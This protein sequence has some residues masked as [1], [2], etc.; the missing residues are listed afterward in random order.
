MLLAIS[1][2]Q[3]QAF[4]VASVKVNNSNARGSGIPPIHQGQFTAQNVT[5]KE[6]IVEAYQLQQF[7]LSGGPG[8]ASAER[9]DINAKAS[10]AK[11]DQVLKMLQGL[12]T[13]RFQLKLHHETKE[14]PVYAITVA[15]NGP[16]IHA[17]DGLDCDAAPQDRPCGGFRVFQRRR[18]EGFRASIPEFGNVLSILMTRI[19]QDNTGLKGRFDFKLDW[20]PDDL[21]SKG[22]ED[23][24]MAASEEGR[25]SIFSAMQEQL[26]LKLE[27]K[28]GPVEILV[29]DRV[30][31]PTEN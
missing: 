5:L 19:V 7:Q 1:L 23:P 20:T 30:E 3:L 28:R 25:A 4:D 29:I 6:L 11:R 31:K 18:V 12:L 13:E 10:G 21:Q 15:K 8:W 26:G 16:K 17:I 24:S 14:M 9:F 2:L 22:N 27:S